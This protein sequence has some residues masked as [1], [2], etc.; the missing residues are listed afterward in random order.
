MT[1]DCHVRICESLAGW[2]RRA[3]RPPEYSQWAAAIEKADKLI[4]QKDARLLPRPC[5]N[6]PIGIFEISILGM[7]Q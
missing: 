4:V 6:A 1:G 2:F 7:D 3:T 5:K